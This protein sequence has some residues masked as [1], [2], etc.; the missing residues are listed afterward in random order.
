MNAKILLFSRKIEKMKLEFKTSR[1]TRA[2]KF[3]RE[4]LPFIRKNFIQKLF[5]KREIKV[6]GI[7]QK[8][9]TRLPADSIVEVFLPDPH[10]HFF[11]LTGNTIIFENA[12]LIAFD[13]R[14]GIS[15]HAGVGTRGNDLRTA[16]EVLLR[17]KLVVVHRIDKPTSGVVIFAKNQKIARLL[18]EEF[19]QRRVEKKYFAVVEGIPKTSEGVVDL[20]L[21]RVG[22]RMEISEAG[23]EAQTFWKVIKKT[24][25]HALL[26]IQIK[27]GRTHQIRAHLTA[28]GLPVVGDETYLSTSSRQAEK[29]LKEKS[30][31]PR[32]RGRML[33]HASDLKILDYKFHAKLPAKFHEN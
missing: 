16:T 17:K 24:G 33:L 12:D 9:E 26:E 21:K 27:T 15:T 1:E 29:S 14:A 4:K 30:L 18:E 7:P 28:I 19:R 11:E 22:K 2:E 3:L 31:P 23:L 20:R 10:K 8:V 32:E 25:K 6:E 13:K 5:R